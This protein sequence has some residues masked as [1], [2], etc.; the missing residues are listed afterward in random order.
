[1]EYET[2]WAERLLGRQRNAPSHAPSLAFYV[3]FLDF[4]ARVA[5][6]GSHGLSN[7]SGGY[8]GSSSQIPTESGHSAG[9]G[10]CIYP[11]VVDTNQKP[12]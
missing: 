11:P 6:R 1:M 9:R 5:F 2:G 3:G 4:Q 10:T 8:I 12:R 7:A